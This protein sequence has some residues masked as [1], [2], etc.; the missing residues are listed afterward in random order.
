MKVVGR[1]RPSNAV[2]SVKLAL[3]GCSPKKAGETN[4]KRTT[5][6]TNIRI[7]AKLSIQSREYKN[8]EIIPT[9]SVHIIKL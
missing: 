7:Y 6:Y 3:F 5:D 4:T 1:E 2:L 8:G 9:C